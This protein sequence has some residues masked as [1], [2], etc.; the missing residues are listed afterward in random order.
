MLLHFCSLFDSE[1]ENTLLVH[2]S[3]DLFKKVCF[4]AF[5]RS[6]PV[7]WAF[8]GSHKAKLLKY[9]KRWIRGAKLIETKQNGHL[10]PFTSLPLICTNSVACNPKM[11]NFSIW[12][13]YW[14]NIQGEIS[15]SPQNR[16]FWTNL[17]T[18]AQVGCFLAQNQKVNK[19]AE[20]LFRNS[21]L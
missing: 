7:Y 11:S 6:D 17:S 15:K 5:L 3:K 19:S 20:A 1:Q 10:R 21:F 8:K 14:P 18:N 4:E 2:W 13:P 12:P 16:P 9:W